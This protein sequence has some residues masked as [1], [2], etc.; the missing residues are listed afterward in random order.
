[1]KGLVGI[2]LAADRMLERAAFLAFDRALALIARRTWRFKLLALVKG[3]AATGSAGV[4][5]PCFMVIS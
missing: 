4:C 5:S 3:V 2:R 1:M